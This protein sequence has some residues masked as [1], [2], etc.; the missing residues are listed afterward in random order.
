MSSVVKQFRQIKGLI[1]VKGK[2]WRMRGCD[3]LYEVFIANCKREMWLRK[4]S[5]GDLANRIGYKK[6]TVDAFFSNL[7]HREKSGNVAK[8]ISEELCIEL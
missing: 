2:F 6:S 7:T 4:L 3:I 5:N 8:A 1:G